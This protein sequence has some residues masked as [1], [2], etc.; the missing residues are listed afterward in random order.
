MMMKVNKDFS[1]ESK[2]FKDQTN[3][4]VQDWEQLMWTYQQALPFAE[5]GEKWVLM[6]KNLNFRE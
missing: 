2:T 3:Q 5:P 1:F 4:K 6:K